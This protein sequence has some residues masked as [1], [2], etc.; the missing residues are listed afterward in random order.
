MTKLVKLK[1]H[2]TMDNTLDSKIFLISS[3]KAKDKAE[4]V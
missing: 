3:G 1:H 4:A 2:K